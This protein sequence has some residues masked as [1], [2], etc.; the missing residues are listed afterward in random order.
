MSHLNAK[1]SSKPIRALIVDDHK[2]VLIGLRMVLERG[3]LDVVGEAS[4]GHDAVEL[5]RST[6]P[7]VVILDVF[8]PDMGGLDILN[9]IRS[10]S[11]QARVIMTTGYSDL[12]YVKESL[13]RGA[14]GY[15]TKDE[16]PAGILAAVKSVV[17]GEAAVSRSVLLR[18]LEDDDEALDDWRQPLGLDGDLTPQQLRV[19]AMVGMGLDNLQIASELDI[20]VN[21]V[22]SHIQEVYVRLGVSDRTKVA[23]WAVKNG[24]TS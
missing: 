22:R 24:L 6:E 19:A 9:G 14:A 10:A 7:D 15:I 16:G 20:T 8:M 13:K 3:G 12:S 4:T 11:P 21:T 5:A 2:L 17:E 23:L 1:R 18:V